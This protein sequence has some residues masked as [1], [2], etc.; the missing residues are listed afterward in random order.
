MKS[1]NGSTMIVYS[2]VTVT[3][4]HH[5]WSTLLPEMRLSQ[6]YAMREIIG[7]VLFVIELCLKQQGVCSFNC[8]HI[9]IM[10]DTTNR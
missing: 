7:G 8:I 5:T 4:P 6:H 2:L 3:D 1:V 10:C 9:C